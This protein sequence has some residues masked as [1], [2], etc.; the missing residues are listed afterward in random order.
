[1]TFSSCLH[2]RRVACFDGCERTAAAVLLLVLAGLLTAY[3][4]QQNAS[5]DVGVVGVVVIVV[6]G[7]SQSS[8]YYSSLSTAFDAANEE[9]LAAM[10]EQLANLNK[11]QF[12]G[13]SSL[14]L[15]L[16]LLLSSSSSFELI[17]LISNYGSAR[18]VQ[19]LCT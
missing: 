2:I 10:V 16:L 15:L 1:M 13:V 8:A 6:I 5:M 3:S 11:C 4:K 18:V 19:W 7:V 9:L 17:A 12:Y 14:L